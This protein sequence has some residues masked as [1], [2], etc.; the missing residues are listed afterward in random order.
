[1]HRFRLT[2]AIA[3]CAYG[4][5]LLLSGNEAIALGAW[6]AGLAVA[7]GY[8]GTPSTEI[9][10]FLCGAEG[11][12]SQWSVN[13]KVA[14]EVAFGAAVGGARSLYA[15]K[16]VGLNVAMDPL[17]TS[18]Y[19]GV[20]GGMVVVVADDPGLHSSQNEQDTRWV[21]PYAKAP[22]IEPSSPSEA[23]AFVKEAFAISERFDTPVLFRITTRVAHSEESV[24]IKG[25]SVGPKIRPFKK[26]ISK[27]VM[28]PD[29][30]YRR[31]VGIE[32]RLLRM[33]AFANTTKLNRIEPGSDKLG[34]IV[35][36]AAYQY[37]KESYPDASVLK[38]GF[39]WPFCD[40]KITGFAK[41]VR[42]LVVVEEL[43]PLI[44]EHVRALG[45]KARSKH[46]SDRIGE[47]KPE[48]ISDIVSGKPKTEVRQKTNIPQLCSACP[49]GFVFTV[50]SQ[51]DLTVTGDI[52]CYTLGALPPYKT[53]HTNLCM[54]AGITMHEGM[55][56]AHDDNKTVGIIGDS[57]FVHSGI[58]GLINTVYNKGRGLIIIL[59][60]SITA[61]T[62][63][64]GHP[65]SGIDICGK[66]TETLS[67][68]AICRAS[69][70]KNV[71]VVRP[72]DQDRLRELILRGLSDAELSVIIA[73]SPC[74]LFTK[75]EK[76]L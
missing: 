37:V 16:H 1:M 26:D 44:E 63:G 23:Y 52:G 28:I 54:G 7:T 22:M 65:G 73:R 19:A 69:G 38:L 11:V 49:H 62:G 13:E 42:K 5:K 53:M 60:N 74:V 4:G 9:L 20:N 18:V 59:D 75:R 47:L 39:S 56:L 31:H 24:K 40:E 27:Y 43:D 17:M 72:Q 21:A 14:Y 58:T 29:N 70:V 46:N 66:P 57:T 25:R 45:I 34:F 12:K 15:S 32:K 64:Q 33:A 61:M 35:S 50:M 76:V 10:E 36:S 2:D 71:D 67:L 55:R 6:E 8:P 68:E 3:G 30:S 51:L 41:S 48:H